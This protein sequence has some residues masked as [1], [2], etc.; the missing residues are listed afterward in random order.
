MTSF[1]CDR[2]HA[3]RAHRSSCLPPEIVSIVVQEIR[4][5]DASPNWKT[6]VATLSLVSSSFT[7]ICQAELFSIV[8]LQL[9]WAK[10]GAKS[11][12]T[13]VLE[14]FTKVMEGSPHLTAHIQ[15]LTVVVPSD[16]ATDG[17]SARLATILKQLN[18]VKRLSIRGLYMPPHFGI[19][20]TSGPSLLEMALITIAE[21]P[22]LQNLTLYNVF[23]IVEVFANVK[24][25]SVVI[26]NC[27]FED[28]SVKRY[29]KLLGC[30]AFAKGVL[31]FRRL[32][33]SHPSRPFNWTLCPRTTWG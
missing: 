20:G 17:D 30:H 33:I 31:V 27:C 22:T 10:P 28:S 4:T 32:T 13:V 25:Q 1:Q 15:G 6:D 11:Q 21:Q 5:G 7:Y 26:E 24:C 3:H 8:E 2:Y 16:T 9:P 18:N 23:V 14:S 29:V 19:K 12:S